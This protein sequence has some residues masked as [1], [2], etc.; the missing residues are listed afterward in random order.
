M[1]QM[2][3]FT[4]ATREDLVRRVE[5][6]LATLTARDA[7]LLQADASERSIACKLACHLQPLFPDWDIDC[8]YNCWASPWQRKGHL[9]TSTTSAAIEARTIFPDLLIHRRRHG[10][11]LAVIEII[12]TSHLQ[13]RHQ[14]LKKLRHCQQRLGCP[15]ALLLNIGVGSESGSHELRLQEAIPQPAAMPRSGHLR[16]V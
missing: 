14:A 8:E 16:V 7:S 9:V 13:S 15:Y 5:Q 4:T 3:T 10:D 2:E 12:L 11:C 6:A 1:T